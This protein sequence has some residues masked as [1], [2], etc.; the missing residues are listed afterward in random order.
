[1]PNSNRISITVSLEVSVLA[2]GLKPY[3]APSGIVCGLQDE[4]GNIYKPVL[5]FEKDHGGKGSTYTDVSTGH[6][7]KA[8]GLE[9][10][11]YVNTAVEI[12]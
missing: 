2:T 9:V 10:L 5:A 8:A 4:A 12:E 3:V 1:M 7:M 6:D 11:D